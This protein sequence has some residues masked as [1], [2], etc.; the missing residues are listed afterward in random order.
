[1]IASWIDKNLEGTDNPRLHGK[2][3]SANRNGQWR[4]RIGDYHLIC[5]MQDSRL[6]ILALTIGHQ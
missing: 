2:A 5:E 6:V 1:M 4:H 3:L